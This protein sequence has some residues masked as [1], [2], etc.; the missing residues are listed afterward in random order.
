MKKLKRLKKGLVILLT[1]AMVVGMVLDVGIIQVSAATWTPVDKATLQPGSTFDV[2]TITHGSTLG[3]D[4]YT[5]NQEGATYTLTGYNWY[6]TVARFAVNKSCTIVLD[7]VTLKAGLTYEDDGVTNYNSGNHG[8]FEIADGITVN[9]V[10]KGESKITAKQYYKD[11]LLIVNGILLGKESTITFSG[12]G[13]LDLDGTIARK[14]LTSSTGV[15]DSELIMESGRVYVDG[16]G[17]YKCSYLNNGNFQSTREIGHVEIIYKGGSF[18]N[19]QD[20]KEDSI[21]VDDW[22]T[23]NCSGNDR[24]VSIPI[25]NTS[26][27]TGLKIG[28]DGTYSYI[29]CPNRGTIYTWHSYKSGQVIDYYVKN[30]NEYHHY[31][32]TCADTS[33]NDWL[34]NATEVT[35]E[36][37]I[38]AASG[39]LKVGDAVTSNATLSFRSQDGSES[40]Q[41]SCTTDANGAYYKAM[42]QGTYQVSLKLSGSDQ[43][44][45]MGT[46][47]LTAEKKHTFDFSLSTIEGTVTDTSS[48]PINNAVIIVMYGETTYSATTGSDGKYRFVLPKGF[49]TTGNHIS[50]SAAHLL[51]NKVAETVKYLDGCITQNFTLQQLDESGNTEINIYTEDDLVMLSKSSTILSNKT[52]NLMAD[53]SLTGKFKGIKYS[54]IKEMTLKGNG[55]SIKNLTTPLFYAPDDKSGTSYLNRCNISDLHLSGDIDINFE[56]MY[57]GILASAIDSTNVERCTFEGSITGGDCDYIGGLIGNAAGTDTNIQNCFVHITNFDP[58]SAYAMGGLCGIISAVNIKNCGVIIDK[59]AGNMYVTA[60]K[61]RGVF[62]G[63]CLD[64]GTIRNC[65]SVVKEKTKDVYRIYGYNSDVQELNCYNT[66]SYAPDG[67]FLDNDKDK[68]QSID[69]SEELMTAVAGSGTVDSEALID[70]LNTYASEKNYGTWYRRTDGYPSP[71]RGKF[72][73]TYVGGTKGTGSRDAETVSQGDSVTLPGVVFKNADS[74]QKGWATTENGSKAYDLSASITPTADMTLYPYWE[75]KPAASCTAP[76]GLSAYYGDTVG[77]ISLPEGFT[78]NTPDGTVGNVGTHTFKATYTPTGDEAETYGRNTNV[79]I[80]VEVKKAPSS[81]KTLVSKVSDLT[82]NRTV[83]NLVTA[84][85]TSDGTIVYSLTEDGE[86]ISTI[87][88]AADVGEYKVYYKI[89]GDANHEDSSVGIVSVSIGKGSLSGAA[90]T[91]GDSLTYNGEEQTQSIKS[92]KVGDVTLTP[93]DYV[94]T[95][96]KGTEPNTYTLTVTGA[97]KFEGSNTKTFEIAKKTAPFIPDMDKHYVN[98]VGSKDA[99]VSIDIASLLPTDRGET[100]YS[101]ADNTATYVIDESVD[102]NGKLNYKIST[103]E[104]VNTQTTLTVTAK[105]TYYNDIIV[106]IHINISDKYIVAEKEGSKVAITGGNSLIYG[107]K[108]S[109]LTLN[110]GVAKF[111]E[112]GDNTKEVTGTLAWSDP[113]AVLSAGTTVAEW[114]FTPNESMANTYQQLTGSVAIKVNKATPKV[115]EMPTVADR[116]YHPTSSLSGVSLLGGTVKGIDGNILVGGWSWQSASVVPSVGNNTYVAAFTPNDTTNYEIVTRS[117]PINV[118]R[119]KPYIAIAPIPGTIIYGDSLASSKISG[120]TV[121]YSNNDVTPVDGSFEW[122]DTSIKPTVADSDTTT[123]TLVFKPSDRVNY[124]TVEKEVTLTINKAENVSNMPN[125]SMSVPKSCEKVSDVNLPTGW[126]WQDAYKDKELT[127][128]TPVNATAEYNGADKDNYTNVTIVIA[129]TRSSCDHTKTE[130]RNAKS[131]SCTSE[132]YSGDTYCKDCGAEVS[133]GTITSKLGHNYTDKVTKEPTCTE[134]GQKTYTCSC[135]SSYNE[136]ISALG[137]DYSAP[138]FSWSGYTS[139]TAT[140]TCSKDASH[141]TSVSCSITSEQTKQATGTEKGQITHTATATLEGKTFTD[142]KIEETSTIEGEEIGEGKITTG[143]VVGDK[144]PDTSIG[145]LTVDVVKDLLSEK[146][147]EQVNKG[148]HIHVYIEAKNIDKTV[149]TTDKKIITKAV[150]TKIA[151]YIKKEVNT[152]KEKAVSKVQYIDLTLYKK[153]GDNKSTKVSDT[154]DNKL[155][156]TVNIPESMKSKSNNGAYYIVR[157]HDGKTEILSTKFDKTNNTLTFKTDKFSTYAIVYIDKEKKSVIKVDKSFG[158]LR[159]RCTKSTS[160]AN[161]FTWEKVKD[162]DGYYVYGSR[163]NTKSK[164]YT[165]KLLKTITKNSTVTWTNKGL[166]KGT[167]YKYYVKAYKIIDGKK[168]VIAQSKTMHAVTTGGKYG[169][170]KSLSVNKTTVALKVGKKFTIKAKEV[171]KDKPIHICASIQYES[172]NTSIATVSSK[173]AITAKK[174]GTCYIYVYNQNG[175]Y[176]KIKVNV[177]K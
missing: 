113:N 60:D 55:H 146:E 173:G 12:G 65:Y 109:T 14:F 62:V 164:T 4:R 35:D 108:L 100:T 118:T 117:I 170:A 72:K 93:S 71:I 138:S 149:D 119:V 139:A 85:D 137:H 83:Q 129:I 162:A 66:F 86:F 42:P 176:K 168:V 67:V 20:D 95:G 57:V 27:R 47:S 70:R 36:D 18:Y 15:K 158:K 132:G 101:L 92:V 48:N 73:I 63:Y 177:K 112:D 68:S 165:P 64:R 148:E 17:N 79:Q 103:T 49:A 52:I 39:T 6:D 124:D 77:S 58:T 33:N 175:M 141:T 122:K 50:V 116:D 3:V 123:Y 151:E 142:T 115:D 7:N 156:I 167:F 30:K 8:I 96:N 114:T 34:T 150:D 84:G 105:S 24:R 133:K 155:E 9:F 130:I 131:A 29:D 160:S 28:A 16:I 22:Q 110:T 98:T 11:T 91:L 153:I 37:S 56:I 82:Y 120:G 143:V 87:P 157:V 163:C 32:H 53:I 172:T 97:G 147:M 75:A 169:N 99:L 40:F 145:N 10:L 13:N 140:F 136:P 89:Q 161:T 5:M 80:S 127:V 106:N 61:E 43:V 26:Q 171:K 74:I 88:T 135:G 44:Y 78:W 69:L 104:S 25:T 107:Q 134:F 159:L 111:V 90:I 144:L 23:G 126:V 154:G 174:A 21:R 19:E 54:E 1:V 76:T 31:R 51:S 38:S 2:N 121:Q 128:G 125:S 152:S 59:F 45:D 166:K 81:Y 46:I 102:A 94:V 41:A